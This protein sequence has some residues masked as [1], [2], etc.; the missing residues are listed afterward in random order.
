MHLA[1]Q[2]I[3]VSKFCQSLR[4]CEITWLQFEHY[5]CSLEEVDDLKFIN[6]LHNFLLCT[7]TNTTI[8]KELCVFIIK[9]SLGNVSKSAY[10]A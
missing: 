10:Q 3:A 2:R 8:L 6:E 9:F 5:F 1:S 4:C 7:L